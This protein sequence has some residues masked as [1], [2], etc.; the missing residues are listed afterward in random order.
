M[1]SSSTCAGRC[2]AGTTSTTG[3]WKTTSTTLNRGTTTRP[4]ASGEGAGGITAIDVSFYDAST[5]LQRPPHRE[6]PELYRAQEKK[7]STT[8][9][10]LSPQHTGIHPQ[11]PSW[12]GI[13]GLPDP[14]PEWPDQLFSHPVSW[15]C[16]TAPVIELL[17]PRNLRSQKGPQ[18]RR[19]GLGSQLGGSWS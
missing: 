11:Q 6:R 12:H 4:G 8:N 15:R 3:P 5:H 7:N 1:R 17:S 19:C 13:H 18:R 10:S 16:K 2:C 14:H 9:H